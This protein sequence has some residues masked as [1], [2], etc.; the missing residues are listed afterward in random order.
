PKKEEK[1]TVQVV[2][3]NIELEAALEQLKWALLL[4]V[5]LIFVTMILQFGDVLNALLVMVAVPLGFIGVLISL[6]IFKSSLSL[7]SALGV[8]LLN[9]ITVANS[10]ILV[11]FMKR[12]IEEDGMAPL[13]AAMEAGQAR[14]RP[15]LMTSLTT[16]LGMMPIAL[17]FGEGGRIL[18]P[19][20]IAVSGG[21]WFSTLL[22]LFIVPA[23]QVQYLNYKNNKQNRKMDLLKKG[24]SDLHFVEG[25][26][27]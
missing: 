6:F 19:L 23:L 4:S 17:G 3:A 25:T 22:T 21:L 9:G 24:K 10:I 18:Q 15:I 2:E 7:N 8:I 11:D 1:P 14:L 26:H 5:V 27:P 16:I 13:E 12:K 20:G